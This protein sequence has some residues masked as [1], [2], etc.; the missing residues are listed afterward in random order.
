MRPALSVLAWAAAPMLLLCACGYPYSPYAGA[1][2]ARAVQEF[3]C[4]RE[5]LHESQVYATT[6]RLNGCGQEATYT[7]FFVRGALWQ[8][9]VTCLREGSIAHPRLKSAATDWDD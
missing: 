9:R 4:P 6:Y 1:A 2:G 5:E 3:P 8:E 7:C